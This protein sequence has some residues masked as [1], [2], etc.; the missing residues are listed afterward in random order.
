MRSQTA[1]FWQEAIVESTESRLA[2]ALGR[3]RPELVGRRPRP[4]DK[5][6][7][8][9]PFDHLSRFVTVDPLGDHRSQDIS[10]RYAQ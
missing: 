5:G 3:A 6:M 9:R 4:N 8:V 2:E 10:D 1:S 7:P